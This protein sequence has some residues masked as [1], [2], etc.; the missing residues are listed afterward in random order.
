MLQNGAAS[1]T[2]SEATEHPG[3]RKAIFLGGVLVRF[4]MA[5]IADA[6]LHCVGGKTGRWK[7][8]YMCGTEWEI[9]LVRQYCTTCMALRER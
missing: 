9:R 6:L 2:G 5:R 4:S 8:H 1:A 3:P 7:L